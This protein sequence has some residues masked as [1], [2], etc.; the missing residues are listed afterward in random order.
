MEEKVYL[1]LRREILQGNLPGGQRLVQDELASQLGTSRIPVRAALQKLESTGLVI[2]DQKGFYTVAT[3]TASDI[4]EIYGLRLLLEPY[5]A[6]LAV[7]NMSAERLVQLAETN[8]EM[9]AAVKDGDTD[10]WSELNRDFHMSIYEDCGQPRLLRIIRDISASRPSF[11]PIKTKDTLDRSS[12]EHAAMLE[13]A[14]QGNAERMEI[15]I[16]DHIRNAGET[17]QKMLA[18]RGVK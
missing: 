13:A 9:N 4:A 12:Q 6:R 11:S 17:W 7:P 16:R 1:T 8:A 14:H 15:L 5:A 18:T 3:F 10:R 2:L